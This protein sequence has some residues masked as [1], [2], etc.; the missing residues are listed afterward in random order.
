MPGPGEGV[1]LPQDVSKDVPA[2][3]NTPQKDFLTKTSTPARRS[4]LGLKVAGVV[5][6][7]ATLFAADKTIGPHVTDAA[8]NAV[9][10]AKTSVK[11]AVVDES[12]KI[13]HV[14]KANAH[15]QLVDKIHENGIDK[16]V[17][18]R[19]SPRADIVENQLDAKQALEYA[20]KQ[21][22][23]SVIRGGWFPGIYGKEDGM[24]KFGEWVKFQAPDGKGGLKDLYV[25]MTFANELEAQAAK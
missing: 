12:P 15:F 17:V 22:Q 6:G 3:V 24:G 14:I 21:I 16:P 19:T 7:L 5:A 10:D 25:A 2:P 4:G 20:D 13:E 23:G 18:I 11:N 8:I 1:P 9:G